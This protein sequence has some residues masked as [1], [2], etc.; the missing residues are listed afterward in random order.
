MAAYQ[1]NVLMLVFLWISRARTI[2]VWQELSTS[3]FVT[4]RCRHQSLRR[5]RRFWIKPGRTSLWW[6]NFVNDVVPSEEWKDNLR[7]SR[8]SFFCLCN[9]LRPYIEL[10]ATAMKQPV[11]VEKQ[12]AVTLY[13]LLDEGRLRK[14]ANA[15]SLSR[16]CVSIII[17]RVCH[18]ICSH[19]GPKYIQLPQ[20]EAEVKEKMANLRKHLFPQCLGAVDGTH[21][22][23]KQPR[24]NVTNY[25][26][27]KAGIP[28]TSKHVA[29]SNVSLWMW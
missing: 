21:I 22:N 5:P 9:Q 3:C 14:T 4:R 23:I 26:N 25:I 27:R 19:L 6:E 7:M 15:F 13:Y 17:R 12:M 28:L 16:S 10:Q 1:V 8:S 29:I 24:C 18:A 11:D 2:Q 20:T